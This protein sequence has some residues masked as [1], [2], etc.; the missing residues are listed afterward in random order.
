MSKAVEKAYK[1]YPYTEE[2][3]LN[4]EWNAKRLGFQHGYE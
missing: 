4:H 1:A 3:Y 2:N